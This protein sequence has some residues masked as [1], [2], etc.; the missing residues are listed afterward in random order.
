MYAYPEPDCTLVTARLQ[1]G[2]HRSRTQRHRGRIC[3]SCQVLTSQDVRIALSVFAQ[4]SA[5]DLIT[6]SSR[7]EPSKAHR[8]A[9][10]GRRCAG[11]REAGR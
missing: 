3:E 11:D 10:L 7:S 5:I 9:R 8:F 2:I 1:I 4:A 6:T